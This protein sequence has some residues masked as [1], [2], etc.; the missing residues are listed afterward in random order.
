MLYAPNVPH[1]QVCDTAGTDICYLLDIGRRKWP[2][3]RNLCVLDEVR[4]LYLLRELLDFESWMTSEPASWRSVFDLRISA[5]FTGLVKEAQ[6]IRRAKQAGE[7]LASAH[8]AAARRF[9][10]TR[11]TEARCVEH[12]AK[13][14][15]LSP[16]HTRHV[17]KTEYGITL[18]RFILETRVQ[19]VMDLLIHS[20]VGLKQI[21]AEC[22]FANDRQLCVTFRRFAGTT[23]VAYRKRGSSY[24]AKSERLRPVHLLEQRDRP[25][26]G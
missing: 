20:T 11:I 7:R 17:F 26:G 24:R 1:N 6:G 15:G 22:G 13:H 3:V 2:L 19:R 25:P 21:A 8:A 10:M 23:P 16:D 5:L 9:V 18:T 14:L 12:V 4:H